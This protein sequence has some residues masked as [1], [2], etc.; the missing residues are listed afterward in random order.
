MTYLVDINGLGYGKAISNL[1]INT[2]ADNLAAQVDFDLLF[3]DKEYANAGDLVTIYKDNQRLYTLKV[4]DIDKDSN[5]RRKVTC[6]DYGFYLNENETIIQFKNIP[7]EQALIK[8]LEK[9][10][11]VPSFLTSLSQSINKIYKGETVSEIIKDILSICSAITGER[12]YFEMRDRTLV[13]GNV[14]DNVYSKPIDVIINPNAKFSV[15]GMKNKV[16]VV[17]DNA[18]NIEVFTTIDDSA[19]IQKYG[20][21]QKV[22]EIKAEDKAQAYKIAQETLNKLNKI[23]IEGSLETLSLDLDLRANK[24]ITLNEAYTGLIGRYFIKSCTHTLKK[25]DGLHLVKLEVEPL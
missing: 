18:D 1:T 5:K 17:S 9:Y 19:S 11:I 24:V 20:M 6:F 16:T 15:E 3:R 21:L 4:I 7:A 8:L 13:F 10:G 14:K 25:L 22:E 2:N 12:Y 23:Q